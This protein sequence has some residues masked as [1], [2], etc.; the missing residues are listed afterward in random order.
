MVTPKKK[1]KGKRGEIGITAWAVGKFILLPERLGRSTSFCSQG[2][3]L[4]SAPLWLEE[5]DYLKLE[6]LPHSPGAVLARKSL[7]WLGKW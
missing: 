7:E 4:A 1:K 5:V 2:S 6:L 3:C